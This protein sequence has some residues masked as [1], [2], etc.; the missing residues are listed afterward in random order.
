MDAAARAE[1][2]GRVVALWRYPVKSM[3][4]ERLQGCHVARRGVLGDRAF[5]LQDVE[6]G[7]IASAK[8]PRMWPDLL[9]FHAAFVEEPEPEAPLPP[10]RITLPDGRRVRTDEKGVEDVLSRA[11]GRRVRLISEPP[12]GATF[13]YY[14][15]EG[16]EPGGRSDVYTEVSMDPFRTGSLHDSSPIHVLTTASL[17]RLQALHPE[18][19]FVAERFRPNIVVE[20]EAGASGFV[21]NDWLK[22]EL[23]I[24]GAM[25]RITFPTSRC[26]MTTLAQEGLPKDPGILRAVA[27]HNRLEVGPL[28]ILPCLGVLGIVKAAGTVRIEDPVTLP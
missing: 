23:C 11:T 19:L 22:R 4:G 8:S 28:G 1:A 14:V 2:L 21:E 9:R 16:A 24:G 3:R 26:V 27:E 25:V 13:D 10:V 17:A 5:A 12:E 15:A 6:T 7:R 20:P 18:G